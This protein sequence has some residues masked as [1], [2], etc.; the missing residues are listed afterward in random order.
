MLLEVS[1]ST[2]TSTLLIMWG[3]IYL[4]LFTV[5]KLDYIRIVY[6]EILLFYRYIGSI[7]T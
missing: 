3:N 4:E 5:L 1:I 6:C 2:L 7:Y